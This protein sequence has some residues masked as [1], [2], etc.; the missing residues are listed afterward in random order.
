MAAFDAKSSHRKSKR[1]LFSEDE[2]KETETET[3]IEFNKEQNDVVNNCNMDGFAWPCTYSVP[4]GSPSSV[5][6]SGPSSMPSSGPISAPNTNP[7]AGL[8]E[9]EDE[10]ED[11]SSEGKIIG[12]FEDQK[13]DVNS[14]G[15]NMNEKESTTTSIVLPVISKVS[16]TTFN[17]QGEL[18]NVSKKVSKNVQTNLFT[19]LFGRKTKKKHPT[20][21]TKGVYF[22]TRTNDVPSDSM[23]TIDTVDSNPNWAPSN[24]EHHQK[25]VPIVVRRPEYDIYNEA[26]D[27]K[28]LK[29]ILLKSKKSPQDPGKY[30]SNHVMINSERMKRSIPP[31]RRERHMDQIAREQ[32]QSMAE[33]KKLFHINTPTDLQNRLI[34]KDEKLSFQRVGT[35]IGRGKDIG[36]IHK[37][38]MAALAERNNIRDKR[39]F[40]MGMGTAR[41]ENGVLYL[42]QIFGG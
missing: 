20:A 3:E 23:K 19:R 13:A 14:D 26:D 25:N 24:L 15:N 2:D 12:F 36:E 41:A 35:N 37:F 34:D 4:N 40:T 5:P 11:T 8:D 22:D 33:E 21:T 16:T 39:F 32:A 18:R 30:A 7:S 29:R 28:L 6:T 31:L 10:D 9:D 27:K 38:M 42:C 1:N 17:G